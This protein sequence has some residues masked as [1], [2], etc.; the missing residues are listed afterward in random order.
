MKNGELTKK[1]RRFCEEFLLDLNATRAAKRA[2]Y[3]E[4]SAY[5]IGEENLRKPEIQKYIRR[6]VEQRSI[7]T[8]ISCDRVLE[9]LAKI[10]F[11]QDGVATRNK[12][13]AL[14]ML[15]KHLGLFEMQRHEYPEFPP[16]PEEK[17][18]AYLEAISEKE[19]PALAVFRLL[20]PI[21]QEKV[22]KALIEKLEQ[23]KH[24]EPGKA[25]A[26]GFEEYY[27]YDYDDGKLEVS[28]LTLVTIM[29]EVLGED[30]IMHCVTVDLE[31]LLSGW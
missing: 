1:Q 2:G 24:A 22:R 14:N 27:D 30:R 31:N 21:P 11:A 8:R 10:A 15:A 25:T 6:S 3:S 7:R 4:R 28:D 23:E 13:K 20:P 18:K 9:E 26:S 29:K 16:D 5:S 19:S 17:L 12:L